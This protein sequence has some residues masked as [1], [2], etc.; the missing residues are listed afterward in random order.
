M[1]IKVAISVINSDKLNRI[2]DNLYLRI[3]FIDLFALKCVLIDWVSDGT[4]V[5]GL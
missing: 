5:R 4:G 2:Y 3:T 1:V